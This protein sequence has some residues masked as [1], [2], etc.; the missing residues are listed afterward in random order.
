MLIL[1]NVHKICLSI[2][3]GLSDRK[4]FK[5]IIDMIT[6]VFPLSNKWHRMSLGDMLG[7]EKNLGQLEDEI[8]SELII[9]WPT[10]HRL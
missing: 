4:R 1:K 7:L 3:N 6:S 2:L 10:Y 5:Q 8:S 9:H